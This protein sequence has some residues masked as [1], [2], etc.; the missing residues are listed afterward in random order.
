MVAFQPP[1]APSHHDALVVEAE[2]EQVTELVDV[3]AGRDLHERLDTTV[4]VAV[5]QVGGPDPGLRLSAVLEPED[6]AVLEE[7]AER[8]CAP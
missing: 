4:E 5:H 2:V 1:S 7:A 8:C 3:L 6:P